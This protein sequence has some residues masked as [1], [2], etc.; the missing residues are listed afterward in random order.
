MR[1]HVL[2][3]GGLNLLFL[4]LQSEDCFICL[5]TSLLASVPERWCSGQCVHGIPSSGRGE[6]LCRVALDLML[7]VHGEFP[8]SGVKR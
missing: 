8:F 4:F 6:G 7:C 5:Y 2:L 1:N 3:Y